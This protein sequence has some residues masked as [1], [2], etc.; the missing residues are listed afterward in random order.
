MSF[1]GLMMDW[2]A[3]REAVAKGGMDAAAID[4]ALP[5]SLEAE[6]TMLTWNPNAQDELTF[7]RSVPVVM[8]TQ[9][10]HDFVQYVDHSNRKLVRHTF[11]SESGTPIRT[12]PTVRKRTVT[13]RQVGLQTDTT[14]LAALSQS[15]RVNGTN[16][17]QEIN[18]RALRTEHLGRLQQAFL[19]GDTSKHRLGTSSPIAKGL[20]QQ[21]REGSDG[22]VGTT[23][24]GRSHIIDLR[25][26]SL[27]SSNLRDYI[28][29]MIEMFGG[30]SVIFMDAKARA[31]FEASLDTTWM[32]PLPASD[33]PYTL[34]QR[35][36]GF[37]TS[38][39]SIRFLTDNMLAPTHPLNPYGRYTTDLDEEAPATRP[40]INSCAAGSGSNS[41]WAS[42]DA[43]DIFYYVAEVVDG[44]VGA[45][46]R[47]PSTA[48]TYLTVA[49]NQIVTFSVT[50][51][52][53]T[54]DSFLV[55]RGKS[56]VADDLVAGNERPYLAFEVANT[57]GGGAVTFY[58]RNDDIPGT[59]M[60]VMLQLANPVVQ[61]LSTSYDNAREA[62]LA[63]QFADMDRE[64]E[65]NA[66]AIATLGPR[67][68]QLEM[69]RNRPTTSQPLIGSIMAPEVRRVES[70]FVF[71]NINRVAL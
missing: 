43:G 21:I 35:V 14:M 31:E 12:R 48:G 24:F 62:A 7:L 30:P 46:V 1:V 16:S 44:K 29:A 17:V 13:L 22:T 71:K 23:R 9:Q 50:P 27:T 53:T 36:A 47:Y 19:F 38:G 64:P 6:A 61:A 37:Q 3:Q 70:T 63:G 52:T 49:A 57:G 55:W 11:F 58:D 25:N 28:V 69:A 56:G 66:V 65:N 34:G 42:A 51:G 33:T 60:A 20:I 15:I 5:Q 40:T 32:L 2:F 41:Q 54:A 67:V 4:P 18:Q 10:D 59:G 26:R 68:W 45:A 39:R 8:A